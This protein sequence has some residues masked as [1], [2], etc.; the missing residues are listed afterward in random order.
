M[1]TSELADPTP[2][3]EGG[4]ILLT[5]A[6]NT[7][8]WTQ[9][10]AEYFR[11]IR[12]AGVVAIGVGT[13]LTHHRVPV[14][15]LDACRDHDLNV[16]EVPRATTF[17]AVSRLTAQL[18]EERQRTEASEAL[19]MQ[20]ELTQAAL[21]RGGSSAVLR[22]LAAIVH[23]DAVILTAE[24]QCVAAPVG[25]SGAGPDLS[26]LRDQVEQ[27]RPQGLRASSSTTSPEGTTIVQP[28]GLHGRPERYLAVWS[29]GHLTDGQRSA[30]TTAVALL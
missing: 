29:P 23:G 3:L 18:I 19:V 24:G 22:K 7:V 15:L 28:I 26:F 17:V 1:A 13:G 16:F 5:T 14:D 2:Y 20:R 10:W 8:G 27:I 9:K 11:R 25:S 12:E 4:E 6:L 30:I 21:R